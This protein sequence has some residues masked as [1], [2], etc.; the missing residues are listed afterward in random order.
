MG[1]RIIFGLLRKLSR[2][3]KKAI[4]ISSKDRISTSPHHSSQNLPVIFPRK[5]QTI[6]PDDEEDGDG[7]R[8]FTFSDGL[9]LRPN[10]GKERMKNG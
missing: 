7:K 5:T 4:P 1:M 8:C 2:R 3:N 10:F 6:N 9:V